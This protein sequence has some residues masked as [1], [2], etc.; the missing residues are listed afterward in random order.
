MRF[1]KDVLESLHAGS[2]QSLEDLKLIYRTFVT[3]IR[4]GSASDINH[5]VH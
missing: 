2:Q 3:L 5:Q 1:V 4:G